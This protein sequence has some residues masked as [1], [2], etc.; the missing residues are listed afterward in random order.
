MTSFTVEDD[1]FKTCPLFIV[2]C[3]HHA[4]NV[5]LRKHFRVNAGLDDGQTGQML[6]YRQAPWRVVWVRDKPH[7]ARS[8][9]VLM[10]ET[11]HLVT[12]ICQDKGVPIVAQVEHGNGDETAAY[13]F[14]FF[15]RAL[16]RKLRLRVRR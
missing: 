2:G 8:F 11:F 13:L 14:D 15:S 7:N 3:S 6:T 9:G 1:L 4:L 10:H 5:Y 16:V 12:R